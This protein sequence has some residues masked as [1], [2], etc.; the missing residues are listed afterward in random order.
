MYLFI[1]LFIIYLFIY[2]FIVLFCLYKFK[3][4]PPPPPRD[5]NRVFHLLTKL[6]FKW[7]A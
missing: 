5:V 3:F 2:L 1:Y 6:C 7:S 4:L